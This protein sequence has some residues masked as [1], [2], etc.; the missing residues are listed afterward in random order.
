MLPILPIPRTLGRNSGTGVSAVPERLAPVGHWPLAASPDDFRAWLFPPHRPRRQVSPPASPRAHPHFCFLPKGVSPPSP[1]CLESFPGCRVPICHLPSALG[2]LRRSWIAPWSDLTRSLPMNG[3]GTA[4][5]HSSRQFAACGDGPSPPRS[6]KASPASRPRT[7]TLSLAGSGVS[8]ERRQ[9][10]LREWRRSAETPLRAPNSVAVTAARILKGLLPRT[11]SGLG[12]CGPS[13]TCRL[14][15]RP[16]HNPCHPSRKL[17][18]KPKIITEI[19]A[20]P[21][22]K[23]KYTVV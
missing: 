20:L 13:S 19:I 5:S 21:C 2:P 1:A 17:L 15:S 11:L 10:L 7:G 12:S 18:D 8:A 14:P 6:W 9:K 3:V 22:L 23:T 16:Q 4:P